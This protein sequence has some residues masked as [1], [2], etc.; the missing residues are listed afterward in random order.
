MVRIAWNKGIADIDKNCLTCNKVFVSRKGNKRKYC[1]FKCSS[2]KSAWSKGLT[3]E[4][5]P[6]LMSTS[7]KVTGIK[8]PS[9]SG[10]N[11]YNW[12]GGKPKCI[13]CG[14]QRWYGRFDKTLL[15]GDCYL[16]NWVKGDKHYAWK[17]DDVGYDALHSWVSREK[18]R[19]KHCELCGSSDN[20]DWANKDHKYKRVLDDFISL[21]R[22]CHYHY[23]NDSKI[24]F[25]KLE[26]CKSIHFAKGLC[27][28]H[29]A[30]MYRKNR[31]N[32]FKL[33]KAKDAVEVEEHVI[34]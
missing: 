26:R 32:Q 7:K 1:S 5:H 31:A 2:K 10:E 16:N 18:G 24:K 9:I 17:G 21:C 14:S 22:K 27:S 4:T 6:S 28:K 30:R 33:D 13:K 11:N 15:C 20:V 29:Y 12:K 3:K 8:R 25:C 34:E 19:P 23:D